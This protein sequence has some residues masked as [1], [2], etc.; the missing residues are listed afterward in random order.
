LLHQ[1]GSRGLLAPPGFEFLPDSPRAR[2][3]RDEIDLV[4]D[5][6]TQGTATIG[7]TSRDDATH[8]LPTS[9][10]TLRNGYRG[11]HTITAVAIAQAHTQGYAPI[12]A[13][14]KTQQDLFE[15]VPPVFAMPISRPR[16]PWRLRCVLI[17]PI[18]GNRGGVLV[19]PGR[20]YGIDS[21]G[22]EGDRTE[23]R[24][25][26]GRKQRIKDVPQAV[27]IEGGPR[28]SRLQQRHHAT[29]FE[30]SPYL[31]EG[32]MPI[33]NSKNQGFDPATT[34]EFMRR[35]R[36]NETVNDRGNLQAS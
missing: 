14:A 6:D 24:V 20:R 16:R 36:G 25:E 22:I 10:Q 35:M 4:L 15:I 11:F 3:E 27:I 1:Q 2:D 26:I 23:H 5:T 28:S 17:G 12:P 13:H 30:P 34:R 18:E 9:G 7:L 8:P 32:V 29:L 31:I 33:Q 21:E 19:Q